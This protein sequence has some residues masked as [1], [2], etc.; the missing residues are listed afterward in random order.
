VVKKRK[1]REFTVCLAA[2]AG[3]HM[4]ELL[5]M[6]AAWRGARV[7]FVTTNAVVE[8]E[9]R[10]KYDCP[11]YVAAECNRHSPLRLFSSFAGCAGAIRRERPDVVLSTGA[12]TGVIACILG[13]LTGARVVWVDSIANVERVSLSGRIAGLFADVFVVQWPHLAGGK[14]EF[15]GQLT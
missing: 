1:R 15:H 2:S 10:A 4:N 13:K 11:V 8:G 3:G 12:A 7:F 14:L 5:R 9:L 6:E